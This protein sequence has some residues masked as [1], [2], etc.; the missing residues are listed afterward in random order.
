FPKLER[1]KILVIFHTRRDAWKNFEKNKPIFGV[2]QKIKI[3]LAL[4]LGK[5][6]EHPSTRRI[7][8]KLER[9]KILVIFHTRRDEWK[10]FRKN[11]PIFRVLQRMKRF[12]HCSWGKF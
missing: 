5:I 1:I 12:W 8:P 9:I 4:L 11:K 7:F 3:S 6:L 2:L 10:N